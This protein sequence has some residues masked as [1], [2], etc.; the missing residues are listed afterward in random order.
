[1]ANVSNFSM[2]AGDDIVLEVP[3]LDPDGNEPVPSPATAYFWMG[4]K[5]SS[6]G[7]DVIKKST[8]TDNASL[9]RDAQNVWTVHVPIVHDDTKTLSGKEYYYEVTVADADGNISTVLAGK[10]NI[11]PTL[12]ARQL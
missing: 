12:I 5:S 1:M 4:P 2:R 7:D 10:L 6:S 3:I 9:A 8:E 11:L